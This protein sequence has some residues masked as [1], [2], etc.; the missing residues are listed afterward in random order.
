MSPGHILSETIFFFQDM[1]IETFVVTANAGRMKKRRKTGMRKQKSE[2]AQFNYL[3]Y[4][5]LKPQ[6]Q[7]V[8]LVS[9]NTRIV[10]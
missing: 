5:K 8:Y 9:Q 2:M 1:T 4:F 10:I 3:Y 6:E 7:T